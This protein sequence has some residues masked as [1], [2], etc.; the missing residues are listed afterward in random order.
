[1]STTTG[2]LPLMDQTQPQRYLT[3]NEVAWALN[4]LQTGVISRSETTPPGSPSVGDAYIPAAPATDE[5]AGHE[6]DIAFYFGGVWNFLEPELAQG[7]GIYV[8]DEDLQVRW[9]VVGSPPMFVNVTLGDVTGTASSVDGAVALFNG[10]DGKLLKS[11]GTAKIPEALQLTGDITPAQITANTDDYSPTGLSTASVLRLSTDASRD[12]T[13]IQ[14][15]ADGRVLVLHNV[16]SFDVVLKDD[17]TSTAANR[18]QLNADIT[19][20]P[21][22]ST[23]IQYDSTSSRWRVIGGQG[24]SGGSGGTELKGLTFTSDTGSTADSDPGAGLFKWNNATQASAT[25][26][27]FDNATLDAVTVSTFW[28]SL[29]SAGFIYLQQADDS[30]IWQLWKWTATPTDGT[31][32]YKF[33][34]TLQAKSTANIADD[35]TVYCQF[36]G[37]GGSSSGGTKTYAVFTP[38]T[39]QPPASNFA[40]LDTR[41]S[42]AVLEFDAGTDESALWVGI[43]PEAAS[44]GS[45]LIVTIHWVADTATSGTCRWGVQFEAM[46]SDLDSD[47]FDTAGTA[48]GTASGTSGVKTSTSITITTIDSIV[49][50]DP[51]R[52]KVYRDADGTSGTDDMTGDA[53]LFAVEV[54]SAA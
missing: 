42:V 15:G 9:D 25:F 46:T 16:G 29:G 43:M 14:G 8:Q 22:Q 36:I 5:W 35:K 3:F 51:Y 7:R 27:Y 48:G 24:S 13:G 33:A 41:N 44:L 54:R 21:N 30:S 47:S 52:L 49:A 53:Q 26:L 18:F 38:M 12:L 32:Y 20:A 37:G 40:T 1:M 4:V 28:A 39:S 6:N 17:A 45:G 31:G 11:T 34:V 23:V 50:G 10:T 2:G 19:V